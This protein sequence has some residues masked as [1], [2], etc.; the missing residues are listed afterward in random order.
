MITINQS[1]EFDSMDA[2]ALFDQLEF[3][4]GDT[5][6]DMLHAVADARESITPL[7]LQELRDATADP[8]ALLEK[9]DDYNRHIYAMYLLAQFREPAAYAAL[10]NF[11][12]IP[13]EIVMDLTG[14]VV[15]MDLGRMLASVFNGDL[16]PIERLIEDPK[17]NEW[18]RSAAIDAL[19]ELHA[20]DVLR[21]DDVIAYLK[22][23]FTGRIEREYSYVWSA[24]VNAACDLYPEE[25]MEDIHRAYADGLV[26]SF[27]VSPGDVDKALKRGKERALAEMR[28]FRKGLI[29]DVVEETSWWACFREQVDAESPGFIPYDDDKFWLPPEVE[30]VVR[31]EPKIGRNDPCPCG[32]GRKYKKCCL[33]KDL[34]D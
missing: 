1:D 9:G 11:V 5:P 27:N 24:M 26:D 25:L 30:T 31:A 19:L 8:Q 28:G 23:L 17:V 21:R 32:S 15:T 6:V 20:E 29:G 16:E 4:T 10:V 7:L 12:A 18:V 2:Q 14:D 22:A 34:R 13:G 33:G 3:N